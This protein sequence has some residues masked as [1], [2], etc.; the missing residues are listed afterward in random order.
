LLRDPLV[1]GGHR[2][3]DGTGERDARWDVDAG[4][5]ALTEPDR[6]RAE[7]ALLACLDEGDDR[8]H[9]GTDTSP[10]LPSTRTIVPSGMRS[11]AS[12]VPTT[13]GMPYSR[14]TIAECDNKPPLSVTIAPSSGNKMLNAS[15]V[16]SVT[17]TSPC[18]IRSNSVGPA[19]RR[20]GPS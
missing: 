20:A 10:A 4:A 16:D 14:A 15:V 17:S 2:V 3:D 5:R 19:T 12:C 1:T 13:P 9:P 7:D 18:W 8:A 6:L 11:V